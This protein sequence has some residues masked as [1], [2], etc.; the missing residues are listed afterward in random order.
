M[1][2]V[3]TENSTYEVDLVKATW[4]R[5]SSSSSGKIRSEYGN[6]NRVR[7]P[8]PSYHYQDIPEGWQDYRCRMQL[9]CDPLPDSLP[10]TTD[11]VITTS[12]VLSIEF[13]E[14]EVTNAA[15]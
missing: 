4:A 8:D 5:T 6:F 11:R 9:F 13:T 7:L 15:T 14:V 2:I 3:K 12:P 10:G 1:M